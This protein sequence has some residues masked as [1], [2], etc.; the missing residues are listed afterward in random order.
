MSQNARKTGTLYTFDSVGERTRFLA[1]K[2][3]GIGSPVAGID[4]DGNSVGD[5]QIVGLRVKGM[6]LIATVEWPRTVQ[7]TFFGHQ[8]SAYVE[9]GEDGTMT[10]S[11]L[12]IEAN[13]D[14]EETPEP[15]RIERSKMP[16]VTID[17]DD[18]D[19]AQEVVDRLL[20]KFDNDPN[21]AMR[22]LWKQWNSTKNQLDEIK[23]KAPMNDQ[24]SKFIKAV[25][26]A[27]ID[28]AKDQ[29]KFI[30]IFKSGENPE[31]ISRAIQEGGEAKSKLAGM[32]RDRHLEEVGKNSGYKGNGLKVF[33]GLVKEDY[34]FEPIKGR[35][36]KDEGYRV[37]YPD[38]DGKEISKTL[39]EMESDDWAI[40]LP[41][42]K[43]E[44]VAE[45]RTSSTGYR[46]GASHNPAPVDPQKNQELSPIEE[47]DRV[48]KS[49]VFGM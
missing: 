20:D 26:E 45:T 9:F 6:N 23:A 16:K 24:E 37:K 17:V 21:R 46:G 13:D 5:G 40:Y 12:S 39:S 35:N 48:A 3:N 11:V 38:S 1:I 33:K 15:T 2:N 47:T 10:G 4:V 22:S 18:S 34:Q 43:Q 41:S 14:P 7:D 28:P 49:L 19:K 27:G 36:G 44:S 29:E 42:L 8:P 25:R 30:A 32:E 31:S